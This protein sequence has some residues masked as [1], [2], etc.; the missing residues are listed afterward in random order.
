M[1]A[2][3]AFAFL[4]HL[5]PHA[6][7]ARVVARIGLDGEVTCTAQGAVHSA[8]SSL[9][10]AAL[11][12][13]LHAPNPLHTWIA[14]TPFFYQPVE[15]D[16]PEPDPIPGLRTTFLSELTISY[17]ATGMDRM[18]LR[19]NL[20]WLANTPHHRKPSSITCALGKQAP[21]LHRLLRLCA[22]IPGPFHAWDLHATNH[23]QCAIK[24]PAD[25][26]WL[27][28]L[29]RLWRA[30]ATVLRD[31]GGVRLEPLHQVRRVELVQADSV[32]APAILH[33]LTLPTPG[34]RP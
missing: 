19:I 7:K 3:D 1:I 27:A 17:G 15:G 24:A 34:A 30:P 12:Q 25:A 8:H 32:P 26:H 29:D 5:I 28:F 9:Q 2:D 6:R 10:E 31:P 11:A 33:T 18:A 16:R 13:M 4:T 14:T 20:P 23:T 21:E 22:A